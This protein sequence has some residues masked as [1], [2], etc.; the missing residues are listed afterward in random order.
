MSDLSRRPGGR[1]SR[2]T[3]EQRAFQLVVAGGTSAAVAVV[4]GILAVVGILG[5]GL[6]VIAVL[7]TVACLLLFRRAVGT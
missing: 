1:V 3:R 2:R 6:P 5:W 7:L 4:T